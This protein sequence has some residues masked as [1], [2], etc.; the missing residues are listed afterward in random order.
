MG[1]NKPGST[2]IG[3]T[4]IA[5]RSKEQV[6]DF[7]L[8]SPDP[9]STADCFLLVKSVLLLHHRTVIAIQVDLT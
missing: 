9:T 8:Y 2:E 6:L 3:I 5:C 1:G 7:A 4:S